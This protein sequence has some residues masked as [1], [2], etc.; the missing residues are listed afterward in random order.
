MAAVETVVMET[1]VAAATEGAAVTDGVMAVAG[2]AMAMG[3]MVDLLAM[4]MAEKV[5][6]EVS[7][8]NHS[9]SQ[10]I[11]SRVPGSVHRCTAP[12]LEDK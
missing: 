4:G 12:A 5:V 8:R 2:L 6:V 3:A 1:M 7:A 9:N 10:C 11:D